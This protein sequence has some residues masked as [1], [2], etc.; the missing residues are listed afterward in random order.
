MDGS[1]LHARGSACTVD[2]DD[3]IRVTRR[4]FESQFP[5]D[6]STCGREFAT[7]HDYICQTRPVGATISYDADVGDWAP[8]HPLG[9]LLLAN[10]P[11]GTTLALTTEGLPLPTRHLLLAWV[12]AEAEHRDVSVQHVLGTLRDEIRARVLADGA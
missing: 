7:L 11:C 8:A 10:C 9:T 5:R 6:C 1:G 3:A 4:Y 2:A 12:R